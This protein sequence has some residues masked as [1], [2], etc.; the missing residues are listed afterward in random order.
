M[1]R[2]QPSFLG[3]VHHPPDP[4]FVAPVVIDDTPEP[5]RRSRI[6]LVEVLV[7]IAIIGVMV[8]LLLPAQ[9][10][11]SGG[12]THS[13]REEREARRLEIERALA[14]QEALIGRTS[15]EETALMVSS[16]SE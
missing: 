16:H 8:G 5:P 15:A 9:P 10:S 11:R 6:S 1:T 7:V 4:R 3:P 14:E 13:A 12:A 2:Y